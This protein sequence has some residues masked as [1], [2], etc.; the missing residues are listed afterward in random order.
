ML[1][2]YSCTAALRHYLQTVIDG[3]D[4][5]ADL[6]TRDC[7]LLLEND[8]VRAIGGGRKAFIYIIKGALK[9]QGY[10]SSSVLYSACFDGDNAFR[11]CKYHTTPMMSEW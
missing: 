10:C 5:C 4:N 3:N 8:E 2:V 9:S 6:T 11:K 1:D 7:L